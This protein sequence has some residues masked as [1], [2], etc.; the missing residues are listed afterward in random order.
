MTDT[1]LQLARLFGSL[2]LFAFGGGLGV[3]PDMQR[4]SE[5]HHW[6]TAKQFLDL[7]TISRIM[8]GPGSLVVALLGE[9]VAGLPGAIVAL[10]SMF[11][12]PAVVVY[13]V[14]RAWSMGASI[15]W[16]QFLA[17][18]LGPVA[19][20]LTL[21]SGVALLLRTAHSPASF[22]ITVAATA[23]LT[24]NAAST[25]IILI[26]SGGLRAA[27]DQLHLKVN[28]SSERRVQRVGADPPV[29]A[30]KGGD[31]APCRHHPA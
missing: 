21:A 16:R 7:F 28:E 4:A 1:L 11:G 26:A 29:L 27:G 10:I 15:G 31:L 25:P 13:F 14:A 20:G 30:V 17:R 24:A 8:P 22:V 23:V 12:P 18:A 9:K 3:L 6:V 2:S 19:V 5:A